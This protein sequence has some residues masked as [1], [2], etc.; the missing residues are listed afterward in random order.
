MRTMQPVTV[1]GSYRLDDEQIPTDEFELRVAGAQGLMKRNG[2]SGLI[3]YG[4]AEDNAFVTYSTN[5]SPRNRPA[6]ALIG[7]TGVPRLVCWASLRDIKREAALAWMEDVKMAGKLGDTLAT[8]FEDA[9][10]E[11]GT[12]GLVDEGGMKPEVHDAVTQALAARGLAAAASDAGVADLM[13]RKRPREMVVV[14]RAADILGRTLDT[15]AESW[16]SGASATD[17]VLA[18]E[19]AAFARAAQDARTLFS[20]DGGRTL[21]PFDRPLEDRPERFVAYAAVRY[22]GYWAQGFVTLARRRNA[23]HK[24]ASEALERIIDAARPGASG[25]DLARAIGPAVQGFAPHAAL[26]GS[27]GHGVGLSLHEAPDLAPGK[28]GAMVAE[29]TYSLNVGLSQG[30]RN[31]AFASAMIALEGGKTEVLWKAA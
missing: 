31:H 4:D 18:A 15:V 30:K 12:I 25:E 21:R 5:Y 17:A 8:W 19:G 1:F 3:A 29:G 28:P 10:I 13:H 20:I 2:W 27:L 24:A 9:G 11:G 22:Q 14:R 6:L 23:V 7:R 26:T 16:R